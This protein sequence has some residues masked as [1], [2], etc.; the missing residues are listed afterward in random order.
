MFEARLT[1]GGLLKKLVEAVKDLVTD[2]NFEATEAGISLQAMDTS[3][4]CLVALQLRGDGFENFRCDRNVTLG[5]Q[6]ANLS[7]LL[8]CA[9]NDDIITLK[10]DDQPDVI[11]MTFEDPKTERFADFSLKLMDIDSEHLGIPETEYSAT[12]RMPSAEYARI[13]K[14]L[15]S[16]GE[17]V[18]I[19]ATKEGVKFSTS[20]D[21]GTA[22]ITVR[23]NTAADLKPEQQTTVELGE[24]V[25]L[26]F[27]LRY[28]NS[29]AKAASLASQVQLS[30]TK[31]LPVVVEFTISDMGHLKFYLAPKI[32]EDEDMGDEVGES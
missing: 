25:A 21:V 26:T 31:D 32:D 17:T 29:F 22:N 3:H 28:L 15:S 9:G 20:G 30:M 24:P 27:A 14:D 12:I 1:Q 16:I 4:V 8:K 19:S 2:G 10:A 5:I 6:L 23:S 18:V 13:C 7:K 11:T